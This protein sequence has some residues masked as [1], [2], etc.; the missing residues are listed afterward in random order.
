MGTALFVDFEHAF[1]YTVF[2]NL[3]KNVTFVPKTPCI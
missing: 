3:S 2:V 1:F